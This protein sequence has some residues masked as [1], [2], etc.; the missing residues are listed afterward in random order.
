M[1]WS[2][3]VWCMGITL[4][5]IVNGLPIYKYD[6]AKVITTKKRK[7]LGQGLLGVRKIIGQEN[8]DDLHA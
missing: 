2:H 3:D 1:P 7:Q 8:Q 6:K 4:L 5:E